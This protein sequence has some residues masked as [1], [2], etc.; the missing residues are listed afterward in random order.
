MEKEMTASNTTSAMEPTNATA[1][2]RQAINQIG[3]DKLLTLQTVANWNAVRNMHHAF[4]NDVPLEQFV[5]DVN[6][7]YDNY[8]QHLN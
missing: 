5:A 8:R 6:E 3:P 7:W 1:Y 4:Q 2:S